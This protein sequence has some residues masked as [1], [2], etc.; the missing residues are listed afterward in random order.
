MSFKKIIA[1]GLAVSLTLGASGPFDTVLAAKKMS[2][3][4]TASV[5]VGKTTTLTV[6]NATKNVKWSTNKK[7]VVKIVKASGKKKATV[8]IKGMSKGTATITAKIGKKKL[9][10]KVTV[11]KATPAQAVS[12]LKSVSV[13][14]LDT[15]C[16]VLTMKKQTPVNVSDLVISKKTYK[17][18]SYNY[19]PT[20]KTIASADQITYRIYLDSTISKGDWLK[21]IYNK[22]DTM[23]KQYLKQV[24][25]FT[26]SEYIKKGT[27]TKKNASNYFANTVGTVKYSVEGTLPDGMILNTKRGV[28]KGIPNVAGSFVFKI[29]ATDE[30]GRSATAQLTYNI[31]DETA[32]MIPDTTVEIRLDDYLDATKGNNKINI[33]GESF[34]DF[35]EI[36]PYGGSGKYNFRLDGIDVPNTRLSTDVKDANG[37]VVPKTDSTS[38]LLIPYE[39]TEGE[40]VYTV[41]VTDSQNTTLSQKAT[42]KVIAKTQYNI[43]GL[44]KDINSSDLSG[45]RL[46]FYPVG[47][48]SSND[49]VREFYFTPKTN[50]ANEVYDYYTGSRSYTTKVGD[51]SD[52]TKPMGEKRG[53]YATELS[54]GEY[55]VKIMSD[56]DEI[57]YQM[58]DKITISADREIK[59][60]KAPIRFYSVTA[61]ANY[62]KGN[63]IANQ[64]IYFEMKD[65]QYETS[66]GSDMSFYVQTDASGA[67]TASLPTNTYAA[68]II[69]T[70]GSRQYFTTDIE[71]KEDRILQDFKV[72]VE[73]YNVSG[74][75]TRTYGNKESQALANTTLRLYN[76][77]GS[78]GTVTTTETGSYSALLPGNSTY[79]VMAKINGVWMSIGRIEVKEQDLP[80]TNFV[81][82]F[83][84]SVA[85]ATPI[86]LGQTLPYVVS[87]GGV[88]VV[89]FDAPESDYYDFVAKGNYTDKMQIFILNEQGNIVDEDYSYSSSSVSMSVRL[90]KGQKYYIFVV[91]EMRSTDDSDEYNLAPGNYTLD[92]K[93]YD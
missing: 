53:T 75:A 62:A 83:V 63:P 45:N 19:S 91:P 40:H 73:R 72:A 21:V 14:P 28:I 65:R 74:T 47:S 82:D 11:K 33:P 38:D 57:M 46:Y 51:S 49:Y 86:T 3:K 85:L 34:Y 10:C 69:D 87:G 39:I 93:Q 61:N 1:C 22:K 9:T 42:V 41:T 7:K 58:N 44:A 36:Q 76:D 52:S 71:V 4:K 56:A 2:L 13:D 20:I 92:V 29:K 24:S 27:L 32:I 79:T 59:E 89:R 64:R 16:V 17:E 31:Y 67:F 15:S 50:S 35:V 66:N 26:S 5:T 77:K 90:S 55:I 18:G 30:L 6:K 43:T 88:T 54:A 81:Y 68:Y 84:S 12:A 25:G 60:V 78:Y 70:D 8:K 48:T 80:G 23:E 37:T